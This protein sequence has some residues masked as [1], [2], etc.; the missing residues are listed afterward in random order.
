ML[1]LGGKVK[2]KK[3]APG[4]PLLC[5]WGSSCWPSP[6]P[7]YVAPQAGPRSPARGLSSC[8]APA[9][10]PL[11]PAMCCS[12]CTQLVLGDAKDTSSLGNQMLHSLYPACI[13][14]GSLPETRGLPPRSSSNGDISSGI[15]T[16]RGGVTLRW[17]GHRAAVLS[18]MAPYCSHLQDR[19][20]CS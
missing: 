9:V 12:L 6:N 14:T 13:K 4:S 19:H 5:V 8:P 17:T 16:G 7:R 10:C 20:I 2:G 18:P 15:E 1:L 3:A 11:P